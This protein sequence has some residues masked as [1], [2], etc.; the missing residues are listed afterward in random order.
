MKLGANPRWVDT[1][2][3]HIVINLI[4][5]LPEEE[6]SAYYKRREAEIAK[7][8]SRETNVTVTIDGMEFDFKIFAEEIERQMDRM[9]VEAAGKLL[10][11]KTYDLTE[12]L[13]DSIDEL[14][15]GIRKQAADALGYN[16][17]ENER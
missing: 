8:G 12:R 1:F 6:Q 11:E 4:C 17:W 10:K 5:S 14:V 3:G 9:I 13:S 16:P 2:V 7:D 15:N